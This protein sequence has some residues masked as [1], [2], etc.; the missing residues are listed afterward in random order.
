MRINYLKINNFGKINNKE[1]NLDKKINLIYGKNESG[2]STLLNFI[3]N[4]LYGISKNKNGKEISNYDKYS[5]W[6]LEEFSGKI[7]YELD[8][9]NKF[10]IFRDFNKKNPKI[11][12]E[13]ME[14]ISKDF[15]IHKTKGNEFFYEQTQIDEN[16]FLKT[17]V[18]EQTDTMLE[19][20]Q[21]KELIQK[22]T[23]LV[24]TGSDNLSYKKII[25]KLNKKIVDEIGT[26]RTIEKPKNKITEKIKLIKNNKNNLIENKNKLEENKNN[27]DKLEKN[28]NKLEININL[29]KEI[30]NYLENKKIEEE[31]IKINNNMLD[32]YI[33][34][35]V[36]FQEGNA[37]KR[38]ETSSKNEYLIEFLLGVIVLA[39]IAI[40]LA[41][42]KNVALKISIISF[43]TVLCTQLIAIKKY[44]KNKN[45][46]IENEKNNQIMQ[47]NITNLENKIKEIKDN[48]EKNELI[49]KN[50]LINKYQKIINEKIISELFLNDIEEI[51]NKINN[52]D[53]E[54]DEIKININTNNYE[55][56]IIKNNLDELSTLEEELNYLYEQQKDL[57]KYEWEIN[58]AKQVMQ[59]AYDEMK[60][61]VTPHFTEELSNT[62]GNISNGKYA[63]AIF[64]D[65]EGLIV[66]LANGDYINCNKLSIGTIDQM[67]LALRLC[68]LSEISKE[69][70][71]II[72]DEAFAYYDDERL[73]NILIFLE[74]NF[75]NQI[76]ILTCSNREKE[77]LERENIK[78]NYIQI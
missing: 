67:Y 44:K 10:E 39:T 26:E 48:M 18:V 70:M 45:K 15:N 20:E 8:N 43:V 61:T 27:K 28:K 50:K 66:E 73:K 16:L 11:F 22:L 53:N 24:S 78:Y 65:E 75:E 33:D 74:N 23:N 6:N 19:K 62:I 36:E 63:K 17:A 69:N 21:E 41:F 12:N 57:E 42:V 51:K 49:E 30:K 14:E 37:S 9:N 13:N 34:K 47:K 46:L 3:V 7:I 64:N 31:K 56:N 25:D 60:N 54:I 77:I 5:P 58:L 72:L 40:N 55:E 71:P 32:E 1:I 2:K 38:V 52:L 59:E 29:L 35:N 68:S 76:I 4:I